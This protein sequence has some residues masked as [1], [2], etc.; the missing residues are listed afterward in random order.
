M[1][2]R[3]LGEALMTEREAAAQ[4][5]P[6][7]A[8]EP[9]AATPAAATQA[10]QAPAPEAAPAA[11]AMQPAPAADPLP[12]VAAVAAETVAA[13]EPEP[14]AAKVQAVQA[15]TDVPATEPEPDAAAAAP[16]PAMFAAAAAGKPELVPALP[17]AVDEAAVAA[18]F[19]SEPD[20]PEAPAAGG[21][22][23]LLQR[24][25]AA[26]AASADPRYEPVRALLAVAPPAGEARNNFVLSL[27]RAGGASGQPMCACRCLVL[28]A[29]P[30][31][32]PACLHCLPPHPRSPQLDG[33]AEADESDTDVF[34]L[35]A[36]LLDQTLVAE[37]S[38]GPRSDESLPVAAAWPPPAPKRQVLVL[39][40]RDTVGSSFAAGADA[41]EEGGEAELAGSAAAA[42]AAADGKPAP[43]VPAASSEPA[44]AAPAASELGF[45]AAGGEQAADE[46]GT[47]Q[48][49]ASWI[50]GLFGRSQPAAA[51]EAGAA[52]PAA[53]AEHQAEPA[54]PAVAAVQQAEAAGPAAA[55]VQAA[56]AGAAAAPQPPADRHDRLLAALQAQLDTPVMQLS[57]RFDP[58]RQLLAAAPP[59]GE[60]RRRFAASVLEGIAA[61]DAGA[62]GGV[63][64]LARTVLL[65]ALEEDPSLA[66]GDRW[67]ELVEALAA[68]AAAAARGDAAF[69][70]VVVLLSA[71]PPAG[72]PA[73]RNFVQSLVRAPVCVCGQAAGAVGAGATLLR[74]PTATPPPPHRHPSLALPV[75]LDNVAAAEPGVGVFGLLGLVLDRV[76][77]DDPSLLGEEP[78]PVPAD[79]AATL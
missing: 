30:A 67:D 42:G 75:Q 4:P 72:S 9:A 63:F 31:A 54:P 23:D 71:A 41:D 47:R 68:A 65:Q 38:A 45:A 79:A 76:L 73:R 53:A 36:C 70:D 5:A 10:R 51:A 44:P 29:A 14:L 3:L 58:V 37:D 50:G 17:D 66:R 13:P 69:A 43:A 46:Q 33:I 8:A 39:E 77:Q 60:P 57:R 20:S 19:E 22:E 12:A 7:A 1:A 27:V 24:L 74:G 11:E 49:F 62:A 6:S 56:A 28:A 40:R 48:T 25:T 2:Q 59:A 35:A 52:A 32:P 55:V 61:A 34:G 15:A 16:E 26:A 21:L 64:A 18:A 78:A